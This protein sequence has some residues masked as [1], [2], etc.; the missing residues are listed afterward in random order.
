MAQPCTLWV[1]RHVP[2]NGGTTVRSI[3]QRLHNLD[4]VQHL[5]GW[6]HTIG[7]WNR[8]LRGL[9]NMTSPCNMPRSIFAL[10]LHENVGGHGNG[11]FGHAWIDALRAI[12]KIPRACC[13]VVLTTRVRRPEN[14]YVSM[15][16]WGIEPRRSH[17]FSS[18]APDNLQSVL[19]QWGQY[20]MWIDGNLNAAGAGW[21]RSFREQQHQEL[22]AMLQH[23]FD[24]VY[25]L[26]RSNEGIAMLAQALQ[27]PTWAAGEMAAVRSVAPTWGGARSTHHDLNRLGNATAIV[28]EVGKFDFPLYGNITERFAARWSASGLRA[29]NGTHLEIRRPHHWL[30]CNCTHEGP[31]HLDTSSV[32]DGAAELSAAALTNRPCGV[33][34]DLSADPSSQLAQLL[35]TITR[36]LGGMGGAPRPC[37]RCSETS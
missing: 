29:P 8:L 36:A 4:L 3:M 30:R 14:E 7:E 18:W 1:D 6:S 16:Q 9:A 27:L 32:H 20:K 37:M 21:F 12:R 17:N 25:P 2:K 15:Y 33:Q 23:D 5:G 35:E 22:L 34:P 11:A 24:L 19:L 13:R 26:E 31:R 28:E 10:E